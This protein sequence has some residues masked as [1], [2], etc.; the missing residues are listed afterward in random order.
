[1]NKSQTTPLNSQ[2]YISQDQGNQMNNHENTKSFNDIF[3]NKPNDMDDLKSIS[4]KR[5]SFPP[6]ID[7]KSLVANL[8][9]HK[10][11]NP[12]MPNEFFIYRAALVKELKANNYKIK[13]TKLS[14]LAADSWSQE[15]PIIKSAY[16]K[17]ARETERQY[18]NAR[19]SLMLNPTTKTLNTTKDSGRKKKILNNQLHTLD[20]SVNSTSNNTSNEQSDSSAIATALTNIGDMVNVTYPTLTGNDFTLLEDNSIFGMRPR[21]NQNTLYLIPPQDKN[22]SY[23]DDLTIST[24]S[25]ENS[26]PVS[27]YSHYWSN[28]SSPSTSSLPIS[29][30]N[31]NE[32]K[33]NN[34]FFAPLS[35]SIYELGEYYMNTLTINDINYP[36][37]YEQ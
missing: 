34:N 29:S 30:T 5:P 2:T 7:T 22:F 32:L 37:F 25:S 19:S 13:M 33:V 20:S 10:N 14:T 23:I 12:K 6:S 26:S 9:K 11:K 4:V 21:Y 17:L 1:M 3:N 27:D 31:T 28:P 8:L 15:P 18:L 24:Y 35:T 16:R 36:Q